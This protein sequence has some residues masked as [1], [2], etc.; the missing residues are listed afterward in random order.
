M[1]KRDRF[2]ILSDNQKPFEDPDTL[3]FALAVK[4]DFGILK[5]NIFH[6]GDIFD[7]YH[8][9]QYPKSPDVQFTPRQ[10]LDETRGRLKP[11]FDAFPYMRL[12]DC[13]HGARWAQKAKAAGIP[14]DLMRPYREVMGVPQGWK[15]ASQWRVATDHPFLVIHGVGYSGKYAHENAA[16]DHGIS[17]AMGHL[18][19]NAGVIHVR[20]VG[21]RIWGLAVG[22]MIEESSEAFDY[23]KENRRKPIKGIGVVLDGGWTPIFIPKERL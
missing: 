19:S 11:W 6:V 3:R 7:Q 16:R 14:K 17:I 12:S 9:S 5:E 8:G 20:T 2:L 21:L 13:N 18:H 23:D 1:S 22:C 15:W 10:E 4:K